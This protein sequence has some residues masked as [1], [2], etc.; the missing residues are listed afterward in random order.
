MRG[1]FRLLC[2]LGFVALALTGCSQNKS[3]ADDPNVNSPSKEQ[4]VTI[5]DKIIDGE[6][7]GDE[8]SLYDI[9][10]MV[11]E[12][13]YRLLSLCAYKD[14]Y[15]IALYSG[16]EQSEAVIYDISDGDIYKSIKLDTVLSDMAYVDTAGS[17]LPYIYDKSDSI[18]YTLSVKNEK[19]TS[20][21]FGFVPEDMLVSDSGNRIYY[22]LKDDACVYQYITETEQSAIAYDAS[23]EADWLTLE[24]I[25]D[26]DSTLIVKIFE[27]DYEGYAKL[28]IEMQQ[29]DRLND[30][31]GALYY[32]G[33]DYIYTSKDYP[34]SVCIYNELKPRTFMKFDLEE[35]AELD[36]IFVYQDGPYIF[37]MVEADSESILRFYNVA[38]GIMENWVSLPSD[39]EIIRVSFMK[40][41]QTFCFTT[42]NAD[43]EAGAVIW[44]VEAISSI[45]S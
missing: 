18:F 34:D 41:I 42:V 26:D 43:G 29:L 33:S 15:I 37:T 1:K 19:Y 31:D 21:Q 32:T 44:D 7:I 12:D 28:S 11:K 20:Y 38:G 14:E 40:D 30:F 35:A 2:A 10:A 27:G 4:D 3:T 16:E 25:N 6:Y 36:N 13:G 45:V 17:G 8:I 5:F 22:T 23:G 24:S 39:Y 9:S